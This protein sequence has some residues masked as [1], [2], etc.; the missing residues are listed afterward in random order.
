MKAYFSNRVY[1]QTL[2]KEYVNSIS[3]ALL[4]FNR[5]KHFSFQTQVVEKRSGTS[6][7][8]KSL[9]L[10][11]KDCFSLNDH[12]ANSAVQES[13]AMMKAQKELQKMHIENKEVQIHSVKKKIKSIKSRLTTLMNN[14]PRYFK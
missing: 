3:H 12:Y 14:S 5:A 6:K 13:N 2:S 4:V 9:H 8:D 7:R 1:K 11:V 10:T